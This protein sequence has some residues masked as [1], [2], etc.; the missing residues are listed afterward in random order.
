MYILATLN[1]A[2]LE[3][4]LPY[5]YARS[6]RGESLGKTSLG[7]I[8]V[9]YLVTSHRGRGL[10]R[11]QGCSGYIRALSEAQARQ[12]LWWASASHVI[13]TE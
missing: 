2:G 7:R 1:G 12:R 4:H 13:N 10:V 3:A 11:K 8:F 6:G 5:I 9:L